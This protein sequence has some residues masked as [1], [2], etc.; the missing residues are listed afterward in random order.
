MGFVG[1]SVGTGFVFVVEACA[2][3]TYKRELV[4]LGL[5]Q[6]GGSD[7]TV[8]GGRSFAMQGKAPMDR[9]V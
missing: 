4:F 8:K 5:F 2:L 9:E 7:R 1:V 3:L 6:E